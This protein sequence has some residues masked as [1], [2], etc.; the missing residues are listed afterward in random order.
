MQRKSYAWA[1]LEGGGRGQLSPCTVHPAPDSP[2]CQD[3]DAVPFYCFQ[4]C[5]SLT[6]FKL[7]HLSTKT[8]FSSIGPVVKSLL[9]IPVKCVLQINIGLCC[10]FLTSYRHR[11][12][13]FLTFEHTT[14]SIFFCHQFLG[15][16][17]HGS[18]R[19][20][21]MFQN[22]FVITSV[23]HDVIRSTNNVT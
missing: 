8:L 3:D 22:G 2:S 14:V 19:D 17:P 5:Y 15:S 4:L 9:D 12:F 21:T 10:G 18:S 13:S 16:A 1:A 6:V 7:R 20:H 11:Y 23:V